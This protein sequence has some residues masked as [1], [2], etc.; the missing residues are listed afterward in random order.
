MPTLVHEHED[1]IR[2]RAHQF[3]LDEGCPDG[4]HLIHWQRALEA[5]AAESAATSP[6][7]ELPAATLK[8]VTAKPAAATDVSLIGGIGPKIKTQLA[9]AGITSLTQI[10]ALSDKALAAL[11]AKLGLK[12]RTAREE[13]IAQAQ[14]LVAGKAPRA[15]T[16]K[17]RAKNH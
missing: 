8:S 16:D 14:E 5:V 17:A 4:R 1:A 11:D 12:G 6:V 7:S 3:W 10:A 9:A 15:K 13:W 2:A